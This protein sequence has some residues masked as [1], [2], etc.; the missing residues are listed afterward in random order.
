[1]VFTSNIKYSCST[2]QCHKSFGLN[3]FSFEIGG[4]RSVLG[5]DS[6]LEA[7]VGAVWVFCDQLHEHFLGRVGGLKNE[8]SKKNH[9]TTPAR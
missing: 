3:E 8:N 5:V 2:F 4:D 7:E 9:G 6:V 1:M